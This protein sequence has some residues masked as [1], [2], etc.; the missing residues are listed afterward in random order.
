MINDKKFSLNYKVL[1]YFYSTLK[2][3]YFIAGSRKKFIFTKMT[4]VGVKSWKN[5]LRAFP[6]RENAS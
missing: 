3:V 4:L 1:I 6:K 5:R 2:G